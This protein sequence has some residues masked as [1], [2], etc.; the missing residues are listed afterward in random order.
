MFLW[1]SLRFD[2][3]TL[4]SINLLFLILL[5]L[6]Y[7]KGRIFY[8]V[9]MILFGMANLVFL[10]FNA[11]DVPFFAFNARR[12]SWPALVFL[13]GDSLRQL[14]QL[15]KNY[16]MML[17]ATGF[18]AWVLFRSFPAFPAPEKRSVWKSLIWTLA[19]LGGGI[20]LIRNS[21]KLKPLLPGE[22]FTLSQA[23]AG[24]AILNT[25]FVL[26]KT[27]GVPEISAPEWLSEGELEA[28]FPKDS[29]SGPGPLAGRNLVLI[30]LESFA[31]EYTGLENGGKGYTPF[32]DSLARVG[33]W[34]PHHFANGRTSRDALPSVLSSIPAWME[35]SFSTSPYVSIRS[36]GLGKS[37][38]REGYQTAFFHGGKNGTMSFDLYSRLAGFDRYIG[39]NEYP[40]QGD[41]D[42]N[43]GIFDEPFL[44]FVNQELSRMKPPFA[45]GIFTLSSHQP[46]TIPEKWKGKLPKGPL[47]VHESIAYADAALRA[48]F[49]AAQ[50]E[51]WF[52]N[53]VFVL[54]ADH[55]QE[56]SDPA[57]A[58][59]P[60]RFDVPLVVF[61]PGYHFRAD[62]AR[63]LQ[64]S[65]IAPFLRDLLLK[66]PVEEVNPLGRSPLKNQ[67]FFPMEYQDGTYH[68]FHPLGVLSWKG[69]QPE[70]DW[71][72][73]SPSGKAEPAG[74][75]REMVA[76]LQFY[77]RGLVKDRLLR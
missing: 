68:L 4:L 20:F 16:W 73:T 18:M 65:D 30:I 62:T 22:A 46:Y 76:R 11:I 8:R 27:V 59:L 54:T 56:N 60:G 12:T 33:T 77:R 2:S 44:Q 13:L 10:L 17:P 40:N 39:L 15:L 26:F 41:Y 23:E 34:F 14:P 43:W 53:S 55:T 58:S 28:S 51:S 50:K 70:G 38:K 45:A 6:P 71:I 1:L 75:R 35:E 63:W 67:G 36:E 64:H 52:K 37:L 48:F 3:S 29:A 57:F 47:P 24:H 5:L 61:A 19:V 32:L 69:E 42:G 72:W 7:P 9:V 21:V 25:P 74:L 66:K 31:T 49:A